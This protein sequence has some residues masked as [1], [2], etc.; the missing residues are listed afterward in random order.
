M[1][2]CYILGGAQIGNYD[3]IKIPDDSFIIAADNGISHMKEFCVLPDLIMGDFDSCSVPNEYSCEI[4][5]FKPEKDDTDLML[6]VKKALSL[7][8]DSITILGATGG[9]LDHTVAALQT[10]EYIH[11]NGANGS[12]IDE[13][14]A[15]FIQSIGVRKYKADRRCYLSVFSLSDEAFVTVKGTKYEIADKKLVR[16]FPLGVS[17][18]FADDYAEI[19]VLKGKLLIIYS[20]KEI[21]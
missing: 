16:S 3:F 7:G 10:L 17:N 4:I 5:R 18:E 6:A 19:E 1:S 9:R 8:F 14:N 2:S 12:V 20:K 21:L 15:C 13:N 11:E